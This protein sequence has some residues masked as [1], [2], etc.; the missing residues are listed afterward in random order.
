[1]WVRAACLVLVSVFVIG[2]PARAET[3]DDARAALTS[4]APD[5]EARLYA[6]ATDEA[7]TPV[8]RRDAWHLLARHLDGLADRQAD[9]V[10]AWREAL[11]LGQSKD[12][13]SALLD[14]LRFGYASALVATGTTSEEPLSL[15]VAVEKDPVSPLRVD[16]A[17]GRAR[18]LDQLGRTKDARKAYDDILDRWPDAPVIRAVRVRMAALDLKTG[19]A[20]GAADALQTLAEVAREAPG[21]VAG[22]EAEVLLASAGNSGGLE[23]TRVPLAA[24]RTLLDERR[25]P[26]ADLALA[27]WLDPEPAADAPRDV[28]NAWL[29]ALGLKLDSDWENFRLD[30]ALAVHEK[31]QKNKKP[32]LSTDKLIRLHAYGGDFDRALELMQKKFGGKKTKAYQAA[33]GDLYFEFGHFK[34]A[35]TAYVKAWGKNPED[36]PQTDRITWCLLRMGRGDK[37]RTR[38]AKFG[39]SRGFNVKL[40][41]RYWYARS[42]QLQGKLDDA[43]VVFTNLVEDAPLEYYGHQAWSRLQELA[44]TVPEQVT[45]PPPQAVSSAGKILEAPELTPTVAWSAAS[46]APRWDEA[47]KP[48]PLGAIQVA[49]DAYAAA[50]GDAADE[51]TRAAELVHLG[52]VAGARAEL[53]IVD[54]DLRALRYSASLSARARSDLLDNRASPR[55]RG[56]APIREAG[57][58]SATQALAFKRDAGDIRKGLRE[59]QGLMADPYGIR[60]SVFE[61]EASGQLTPALLDASGKSIYPLAYPEIVEPL[62]KQFGIPAYF[63]YAIMT[64]ESGFHS[65]AVS[66]SNAYG[67]VQVIPR[68]GE[69]LADELG[70]LDFTPELLLEPPVSIYFG[71]YY[72]ARLLSRFRGQ[73]PLAA[74]AYNAGPHRVASWLLARGQIDLDMFIEDIP[75]DQA[76]GYVKTVLEHISNYRRIY[77][78]EQHLYIRNTI[79]QDQG[80]GPN[81]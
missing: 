62:S 5:A 33:L 79:R 28:R 65:G 47:P 61:G 72:L 73:E 1:M 15:F 38:W 13:P 42:L 77:H 51:I 26:Q 63:V 74:A 21:S 70:Y 67:L 31:L 78:G 2:A 45:P 66:V 23:P 46:L 7:S 3:Y 44:G 24:I 20:P 75:Y 19:K 37:A 64:V 25:Y 41:D 40:F 32:G 57:R 29:D 71:G 9:A 53:R 39:R 52:D 68:T 48:A 34:E 55:A 10:I 16:A 12:A 36:P 18:F 49:I 43:K 69:N 76:R 50:H 6:V 35:Y 8:E 56:G 80:A 60:R 58:K 27:P 22:K 14:A 59:L 54:M 17:W 4:G 81:Y 30:D 11:T